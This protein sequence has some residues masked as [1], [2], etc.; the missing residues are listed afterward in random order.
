V[1]L[2][3]EDSLFMEIDRLVVHYKLSVAGRPVVGQGPEVPKLARAAIM[4]ALRAVGAPGA[5]DSAAASSSAAA[6]GSGESLSV[7]SIDSATTEETSL[8][9]VATYSADASSSR[10][11]AAAAAV[12][13]Q[14]F[15]S[16][17]PAAR[18]LQFRHPVVLLHGFGHSLFQWRSIWSE[19][20]AQ[21]TI[22]LAFDRPGFGLTSRPLRDAS[23]S[24]GSFVVRDEP[25]DGKEGRSHLVEQENPYTAAYSQKLLVKLLDKLGLTAEHPALFVGHSTGA[26]TAL[27]AAIESPR[28]CLGLFLVS[29]HVLTSG[30]PDL[31]K[32]LLKTKL[33]ALITQ[34]LVRSEM[35]EVTLKRAWYNGANVPADV[36]QNYQRN[37]AVKNHMAALVEIAAAAST[38]ADQV[39]GRD[40]L[41]NLASCLHMLAPG[42]TDG[43]APAPPVYIVHG[44]QDRLV[45]LSESVRVFKL[46]KAEDAPVT[47]M[48]VNHCGHVPHEEYPHLFLEHLFGFM[49]SLELPRGDGAAASAAPSEQHISAVPGRGGSARHSRSQSRATPPGSDEE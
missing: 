1:A 32:S 49:H 7:S 34:Q 2:A 8:R 12:P 22:L 16:L 43:D 40:R 47:L 35:G 24:Y 44:I 28:R 27:R 21:C 4:Q 30:F 19:L 42:Q 17:G 10:A 48:K 31:I 41:A 33:G 26:T 36:L 9:G 23:G 18:A 45:D 11:A 29:P 5:T 46:L 20:A 37:L 15:A 39:S 38:G 6:E 25:R 13:M 3:D 14:P